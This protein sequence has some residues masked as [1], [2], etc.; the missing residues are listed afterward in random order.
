LGGDRGDEQKTG[1]DKMLFQEEKLR[2]NHGGGEK[3][4]GRELPI[5]QF[6]Y[7]RGARKGS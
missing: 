4:E 6:F 3:R 5:H 2:K 1:L 7:R